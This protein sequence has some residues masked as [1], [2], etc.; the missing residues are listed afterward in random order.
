[1][2][3]GRRRPGRQKAGKTPASRV[4]HGGPANPADA[5]AP[6][7]AGLIAC[8]DLTAASEHL[9]A[10]LNRQPRHPGLWEKLG[11]VELNRGRTASAR[12]AMRRTLLLHPAAPVAAINL[13]SLS[14][15]AVSPA[16]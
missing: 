12:N 13:F 5:L 11:V 8:D 7:V 10:F 3:K 4:A 1:M 16:S 9:R 2:A 15:G 14:D 6:V